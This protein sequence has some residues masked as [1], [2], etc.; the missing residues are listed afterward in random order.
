MIGFETP[1]GELVEQAG[2]PGQIEAERRVLSREPSVT[3]V[4]VAENPCTIYASDNC[5]GR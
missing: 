2:N 5:V 1:F 4:V 3:E